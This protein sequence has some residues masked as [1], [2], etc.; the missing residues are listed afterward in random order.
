MIDSKRFEKEKK[1][2]TKKGQKLKSDNDFELWLK[3][4]Y[5]MQVVVIIKTL[6]GYWN[7]DEEKIV[8]AKNWKRNRLS[9]ALEHVEDGTEEKYCN[10]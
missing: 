5:K 2:V 3:N 6:E 1:N 10:V 8:W 4:G 7:W 9:L